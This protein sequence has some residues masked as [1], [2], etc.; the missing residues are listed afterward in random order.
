MDHPALLLP[1]FANG[2][3]IYPNPDYATSWEWVVWGICTSL[4]LTIG[5]LVFI[6]KPRKFGCW[7]LLLAAVLLFV[8]WFVAVRVWARGMK[9]SMDANNQRLQET[10]P[11]Q[12]STAPNSSLIK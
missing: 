2:P 1:V 3:P 11:S 7:W 12:P 10:A 5:G 9:E 6:R 8:G 4:G